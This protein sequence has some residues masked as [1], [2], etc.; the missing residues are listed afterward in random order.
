MDDRERREI[1]AIEV[2][3]MEEEANQEREREELRQAWENFKQA[4]LEAL[5]IP[6]LCS[7]LAGKIERIMN[8]DNTP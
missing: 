6:A 3:I 5:K 8:K 1:E 2:M 7:W 4:M